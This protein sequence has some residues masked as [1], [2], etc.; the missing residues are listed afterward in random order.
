VTVGDVGMVGVTVGVIVLVGVTVGDV[1][2]VGV[3]VGVTVLVGVGD[4]DTTPQSI[5]LK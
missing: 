2:I 1:G 3:T 5:I 4:I